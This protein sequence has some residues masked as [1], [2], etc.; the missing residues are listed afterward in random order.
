MDTRNGRGRGRGRGRDRGRGRGRGRGS[1]K[2]QV[3]LAELFP[4]ELLF[5]PKTYEFLNKIHEYQIDVPPVSSIKSPLCLIEYWKSLP[6]IQF[7]VLGFYMQHGS[8][9]YPWSG[10][11]SNF[12][13]CS[14]EFVLPEF[15]G[16]PS[17]VKIHCTTSEKAIMLCK[18]ALFKNSTIFEKIKSSENPKEIKSLGRLVKPFNQKIWDS[19]ICKIAFEVIFQKFS[20]G[21]QE[22][23]DALLLTQYALIAETAIKDKI[24]GIGMHNNNPNLSIPNK[25][26]GCN[27]LG[28]A[29]MRT[30][31][32]LFGYKLNYTKF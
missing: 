19:Y 4:K 15:L 25:W 9:Q 32:E 28:W 20:K 21:P 29:L 23:R 16:V 8:E 12:Y 30:R 3:P 13:P 11:F 31:I 22:F 18:A 1:E 26:N 24:W 5:Y 14:F 10:V 7:Q 2:K 27:I 17:G 6:N